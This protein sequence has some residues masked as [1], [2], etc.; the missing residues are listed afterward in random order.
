MKIPRDIDESDLI[1]AL[2]ILDYGS[3]RQSG[4]HIRLTTTMGGTHHV[5]VPNQRP[6]KTGTLLGG[7]LNPWPL[8]TSSPSRNCSTSWSCKPAGNSRNVEMRNLTLPTQVDL[9]P[10]I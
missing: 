1:R 10:D 4:S 9:Q 6:L 5:T 7:V 3:V 2:R 8:T